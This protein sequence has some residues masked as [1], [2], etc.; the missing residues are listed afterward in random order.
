M[1]REFLEKALSDIVA[2]PS[3]SGEEEAVSSYIYERL[4]A[5][6]LSPQ[7]DDD[8]NVWV[9]VGSGRGLLHVNAHTDTVIPV[10]GWDTDPHKPVVTDGK[11]YGLGS[12]DCGGGLAAMLW[13][14]PRVKP[15]VRV[16]FSW[17]VCEEGIRNRKTNGS[18]RMAERGGDWAITAE[19]SCTLD[20][21]GISLGTQGHARAI[22]TFPGKAAHSSR[23]DLGKNAVYRACRFCLELEQL[24]AQFEEVQ[25]FEDIFARPS[26]AATVISGGKLS[27]IIPDSCAVTVSRRLAPGEQRADFE[28]EIHGLAGS[29]GATAEFFGDGPCAMVDLEGALFATARAASEELLGKPRYAWQRGRTDAVIYAAAGMDTLTLGPGLVGQAHTANEHLDLNVAADCTRL[30][31]KLINNLPDISVTGA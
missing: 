25:V 19:P 8:A 13:L 15:H 20:G 21:P 28:A 6:G 31:E 1:P 14:A 5:S 4:K 9:E 7:R 22:V 2:I 23:P 16:L 17:T 11:L 12:S 24:N 27:N 30:L 3:L 10:Q 26:V 18:R 29:S